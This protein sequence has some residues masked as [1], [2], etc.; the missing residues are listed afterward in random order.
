MKNNFKQFS[1][2]HFQVGWEGLDIAPI[3]A[4]LQCEFPGQKFELF[5]TYRAFGVVGGCF[6]WNTPSWTSGIQGVRTEDL[7]AECVTRISEWAM[8]VKNNP[9][10]AMLD[11]GICP[12][13]YS[14]ALVHSKASRFDPDVYNCD[15]CGAHEEIS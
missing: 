10:K 11:Y 3:A 7:V 9:V 4:V 14:V 13:C 1:K 8:F 6:T 2:T 15:H 12:K 5:A